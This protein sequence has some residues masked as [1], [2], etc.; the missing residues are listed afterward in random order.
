MTYT[1]DSR[2]LTRVNCYGQRFMKPGNYPYAIVPA[3]GQ[4]L[5]DERPF[6]VHVSEGEVAKEMKQHT[7]QVSASRGHFTVEKEI[8]IRPGD[9]VLWNC[10]EAKAPAYVIVGDKPFFCSARLL[11]ESGYTHAFA[12]PGEYRWVDV[13]GSGAKG[14][15][16]VKQPCLESA[17]DIKR[18]HGRLGKATVVM[19]AGSKVEPHH[20]EIEVGQ[21]VFFAV[22]KG[23]GISITHVDSAKLHPPTAFDKAQ[24]SRGSAA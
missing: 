21:T 7:L 1:F 4:H 24:S 13:Y 18:W 22:S 8:S 16:S 12:L 20:V 2:A 6:L 14:V 5:S 9:L 10:H 11:N 15:V 3:G 23:P 17:E 19:I